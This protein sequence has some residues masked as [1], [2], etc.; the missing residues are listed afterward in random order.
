L[1]ADPK[2]PGPGRIAQSTTLF[3][4]SIAALT[5]AVYL[6]GLDLL[7][8]ADDFNSWSKAAQAESAVKLLLSSY[9]TE[10]FRPLELLLVKANLATYGLRPTLYHL[11]TILG[12]LAMT[13]VVFALALRLGFSRAAAIGAALLFGISQTNAMAVLSADTAGQV[14]CTLLGSLA[15]LVLLRPAP[16]TIATAGTASA[17][18]FGSLLW[19]DAGVSFLAASI[20]VLVFREELRRKPRA[21]IL[22]IAV[23]VAGVAVYMILRNAAGV[24]A[25]EFGSE[26]RY[27]FRIGLNLPRNFILMLFSAV[28]PIGSTILLQLKNNPVVLVPALA[29]AVTTAGL[30]FFGIV[31]RA[32]KSEHRRNLLLTFLLLLA[33]LFPEGL[34]NRVSELYTYKPNVIL[35]ILLAAGLI[36]I[37][38]RATARD[39]FAKAGLVVLA[40]LIATANLVS[41][42][43]KESLMREN[44]LR[45]ERILAEVRSQVP[46]TEP[47]TS[48]IAVNSEPAA[49]LN[50]SVFFMDGLHLLADGKAFEILYDRK[51]PELLYLQPGQVEAFIGRSGRPHL[52]IRYQY[53]QAVAAIE[54]PTIP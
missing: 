34:L 45:T 35:S 8:Y 29:L 27:Q 32:K 13:L 50:Y 37:A 26:G 23:I 1:A 40:L 44:G 9:H 47:G 4:A 36:E 52:V 10:F 33:L 6:S 54:S 11:M 19:K 53:D 42:E 5:G 39:R 17:L 48:I 2:T 18:L 21:L 12:H 24:S 28:S 31:L 16:H 22:S 51:V 3:L 25:P 15:L 30:G 46:H 38:S 49:R 43:H 20:L 41:I 14:F 7:P